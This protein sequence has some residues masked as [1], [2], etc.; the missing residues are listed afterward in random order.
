MQYLSDFKQMD[1]ADQMN[2]LTSAG[3]AKDKK[4][5]PELFQL[6]EE[7]CGDKTVDAMV[8]HT[9]RDILTVHESETVAK[10]TEGTYKEKKLCVQIAGKEKFL[11]AIPVLLKMVI[12]EKDIDVLTGVFIAMSSI[13]DPS[14]LEIFRQHINHSNEVIA[15]LCISMNGTIENRP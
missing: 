9:L 15:G 8:E 2:F 10:L 3:Q 7:L 12:S 6:Y 11:S 5:L 13:K 4:Y 14:F 1:F